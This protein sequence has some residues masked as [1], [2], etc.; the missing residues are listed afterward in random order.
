MGNIECLKV[1]GR[2]NTLV[3][4][5][6][7]TLKMMRMALEANENVARPIVGGAISDDL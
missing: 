4:A 5:F 2:R 3:V 7:C 6:F 1:Q